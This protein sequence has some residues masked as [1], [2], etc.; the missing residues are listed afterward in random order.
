[1]MPVELILNDDYLGLYFIVENIR[2]EKSRVNIV[3]QDNGEDDEAKVSGGWLLEINNYYEDNQIYLKDNE[4]NTLKIQYHSPD[5]LSETQLNYLA[6]YLTIVNESVNS[7]D[8]DNSGWH[9]FI[10]G[11]E[12]A[13]YYIVQEC[14][15]NPEGFRGS[16]W[17]YKDIGDNSK[18]KF[19]PIWDLGAGNY[20]RN[21][22]RFITDGFVVLG[23]KY[24]QFWITEI[25][26]SNHFK[27]ILCSMWEN[28]RNKLDID[29]YVITNYEEIKA[30]IV[31]D[32]MRWPQ[33]DYA[34]T[35]ESME[36][37]LQWYKMKTDFLDS[38]WHDITG[39]INIENQKAQLKISDDQVEFTNYD[40]SV[41]NVTVTNM[42]GIVR[43]LAKIGH[44][45]YSISPLSKGLYCISF[46][47]GNCNYKQ[48]ILVN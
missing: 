10:D 24:K 28:V 5:S 15:D 44:N 13:K 45:R 12:L 4:D 42:N 39:I 6:N 32:H 31:N 34:Y 16:C 20:W 36:K 29:E 3:E 30:A 48:I 41:I 35:K 17:M 40:C 1:M 11:Y 7:Y 33:Y 26:K 46:T 38:Q 22:P 21:E 18:L 27:Q 37:F 9:N 19:G 47:I 25:L 23:H 8:I 14:I 2:V 43:K